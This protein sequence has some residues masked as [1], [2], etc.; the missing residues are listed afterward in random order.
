MLSAL[1]TLLVVATAAMA[2]FFVAG[3]GEGEHTAELGKGSPT[4]YPVKVA[5]SD[6]LTPGQS[7]PIHFT[8]EPATSTDIR[9]L[10]VTP[11]IDAEHATAG[12]SAAWFTVSTKN[13]FWREVLEGRQNS[14]TKVTGGTPMDL[15]SQAAGYELTFTDTGA[16]QDAC[17]GA[18]LTVKALATP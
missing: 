15:E 5:F 18:H 6:G 13:T 12:C 4:N 1:V 14:M 7:E 17:E 8:L 9:S 2:Y 10:A 16:N 11:S 3:L